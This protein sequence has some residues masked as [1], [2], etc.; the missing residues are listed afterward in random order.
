MALEFLHSKGIAHR[1]LKPENIMIDAK[2]HLKIVSFI[3]FYDTIQTDFGD[4]KLFTKE[5]LRSTQE[6]YLTK[7]NSIDFDETDA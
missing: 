2:Y 3:L 6:Q 4:S 7:Q 1:D 5:D